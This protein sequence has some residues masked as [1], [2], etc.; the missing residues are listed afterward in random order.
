MLAMHHLLLFV[1]RCWRLLRAPVLGL[2][3]LGLPW[4][5]FVQLA[6]EVWEGEGLPGDQY[7]L[8]WLHAHSDPAQ[9]AVAAWLSRAGGRLGAPLLVGTLAL[10]LLLTRRYRALRFFSLS[11]VG[12]GLLNLAA[13]LL[14]TRPRPALWAVLHPEL[15]YSFPSGH[16]MAAAALATA[17]GFLLWP[18]RG[19][20]AAVGVGAAW[21]LGLGWARMYLGVHYPSDVLAGWLG[22]VGWVSGLHLLF[23]HQLRA[24]GAG[25]RRVASPVVRW[26]QKASGPG[27]PPGT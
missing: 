18:T 25:I 6:H 2:L 23:A 11:V 4:L 12:A 21:A 8:T 26:Y 5:L 27:L 17:V 7:I 10:G 19:R 1:R 14:L 24:V 16:A 3:A 9:D 13:K 22:S 20:W 15:S